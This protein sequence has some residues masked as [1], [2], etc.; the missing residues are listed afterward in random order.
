M[1]ADVDKLEST[2]VQYGYGPPEF[3][4]PAQKPAAAA[5]ATAVAAAAAL[6]VDDATVAST[7]G[8]GPAAPLLDVAGGGAEGIDAD[9]DVDDTT[10]TLDTAVA[11]EVNIDEQTQRVMPT[12]HRPQ[13]DASSDDEPDDEHEE[14]TTAA[15]ANQQS[16]KEVGIE[17]A[18][19]VVSR[20]DRAAQE[21]EAKAAYATAQAEAEAAQLEAEAASVAAATAQAAAQAAA[22]ED[23]FDAFLN[24][25]P[26]LADVGLSAVSMAALGS[27]RQSSP[28]EDTSMSI[29]NFQMPSAQRP[30][31][32]DT[33]DLDNSLE[34]TTFATSAIALLDA[35][36]AAPVPAVAL[37]DNANEAAPAPTPAAEEPVAVEDDASAVGV[38][39]ASSAAAVEGVEVAAPRAAEPAPP[40]A[41]NDVI[42]APV[43]AAEYNAMPKFF[44]LTLTLEKLNEAIGAIEDCITQTDA[45]VSEVVFTQTQLKEDL[46]L[47][48]L[49]KPVLLILIRLKRLEGKAKND[50]G[51]TFYCFKS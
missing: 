14:P 42:F 44:A 39:E 23:E 17:Q 21:A 35:Q 36:A 1:Q 22:E 28:I 45:P 49:A 48:S 33:P 25:I 11:M 13:I 37:A 50:D 40:A 12:L 43:T 3:T 8:A 30:E 47:G 46:G 27:Q 5:V 51:E 29:S 9:D 31:S 10:E 15:A 34:L 7:E 24:N 2:L 20:I 16:P 4:S 6:L 26:S 38:G 41:P 19:A 18:P 32:V